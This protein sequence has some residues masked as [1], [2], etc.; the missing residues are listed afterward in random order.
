M[1]I[2]KK[3]L[4]L[5]FLIGLFVPVVADAAFYEVNGGPG[6]AVYTG[7]VPCGRDLCTVTSEG[8]AE[9]VQG[10]ID[11]TLSAGGTP[12]HEVLGRACAGR[13]TME[14]IPCQICHFFMM[15]DGIID[16]V[17]FMLVPL[18]AILT[19]SWGGFM[20]IF[21]AGDPYKV[22]RARQIFTATAIGL[23]IIFGAFALISS[24]LT[25]PGFVS[26]SF[27]FNTILDFGN[28]FAPNCTVSIP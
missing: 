25:L 1:K 21:A 17:L 23:A 5:F 6:Q 19:I 18:I 15:A 13:G 10:R 27:S 26:T 20:L 16:W 4:L 7:F 9:D 2:M 3:F 14:S 24:I 8:I 28:W 12:A 22:Q 11:A